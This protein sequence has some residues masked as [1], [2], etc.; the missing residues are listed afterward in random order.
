MNDHPAVPLRGADR[1]ALAAH[2]LAL[3]AEDRRLRFG[4]SP[5]NAAVSAYVEGI[6]LARDCVYV[7]HD[8]ALRIVGA[9]HVAITG[10]AA[11][12]GLSVLPAH[13]GEG[14]G[15]ALLRRAL[16]FLRNRDAREVFVHCLAENRA[17]LHLARR[18]GMRVAFEGAEGGARLALDPPT[19][20]SYC[21][22]WFDDN[23]G[24]TVQALLIQARLTRE[25]PRPP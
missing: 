7:V 12:L 21:L 19:A 8:E 2:F 3:D 17:M 5:G 16:T 1:P 24:R 18:N 13:R 9:V 4:T 22:E 15:D 11:E 23:R 20:H 6:D 10:A 25:V 14:V